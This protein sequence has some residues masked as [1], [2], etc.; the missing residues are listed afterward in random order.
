[1]LAIRRVLSAKDNR[2]PVAL[3][4]GC[5]LEVQFEVLLKSGVSEGYKDLSSKGGAF[6][7]VPIVLRR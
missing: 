4:T 2:G 3:S 1:M 7:A 6:V 5:R